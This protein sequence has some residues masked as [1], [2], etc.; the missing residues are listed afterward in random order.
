MRSAKKC[1]IKIQNFCINEKVTQA[2]ILYVKE[3]IKAG[4]N[5]VQI[6]DN[7]AAALEEQ[8][9]FEFG[10]NYIN[11]IVDS[12][13]AEF[14]DIPVIVFPKGIS[15]YLDKIS[16]KFDVLELIGARRS[17]LQKKNLAQDTSFK[18]IWSQQGYIAKGD[19][20]GS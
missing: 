1:S 17:S 10:F 8:A 13:K 7:W 11:K 15:G 12:V 4:V 16:G 2:L 19:R 18:A 6:F 20:R 3:Q 14:P 9:Y 5:A